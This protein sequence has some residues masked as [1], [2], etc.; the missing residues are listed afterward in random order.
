MT[1]VGTDAD[2]SASVNKRCFF[3]FMKTTRLMWL[4][5]GCHWSRTSNGWL[6]FVDLSRLSDSDIERTTICII[7]A[8]MGDIGLL[9]FHATLNNF[10]E[11][12]RTLETRSRHAHTLQSYRISRSLVRWQERLFIIP[13]FWSLSRTRQNVNSI[14][15]SQSSCRNNKFHR[16]QDH[17][18]RYFIK[19]LPKKTC[20][21]IKKLHNLKK[22]LFA[23][24]CVLKKK[25]KSSWKMSASRWMK[26]MHNCQC[27]G[28]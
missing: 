24:E 8:T 13:V 3:F 21:Q 12:W 5:K 28:K 16:F 4:K 2:I 6:H 22:F 7:F 9:S 14:F 23:E 10:K 27:F 17:K 18:E 15:I 20:T 19:F 11:H 26:R 25:L 1:L